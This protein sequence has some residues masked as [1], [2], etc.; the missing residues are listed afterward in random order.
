MTVK[1]SFLFHNQFSESCFLLTHSTI[2]PKNVR[3]LPENDKMTMFLV[4]CLL[5]T[6]TSIWMLFSLM[7]KN[8]TLLAFYISVTVM[9][10]LLSKQWES[11]LKLIPRLNVLNYPCSYTA[12][13]NLHTL[14]MVCKC[15]WQATLSHENESCTRDK[16]ELI[17]LLHTSLSHSHSSSLLNGPLVLSILCISIFQ[18]NQRL[19]L[20]MISSC[21]TLTFWSFPCLLPLCFCFHPICFCFS[22]LSQ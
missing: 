2:K 14:R 5:I 13:F 21:T 1:D 10:I 19:K 20:C 15:R 4:I 8:A 6:M 9:T 18:I 11:Q 3:L 12:P 7:L 16:D 17:W 22:K